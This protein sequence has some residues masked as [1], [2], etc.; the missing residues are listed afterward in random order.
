MTAKSLFSKDATVEY[1]VHPTLDGGSLWHWILFNALDKVLGGGTARSRGRAGALARQKARQL[2]RRIRNVR[3]T[4]LMAEGID[5]K[6]FI[7]QMGNWIDIVHKCGYKSTPDTFWTTAAQGSPIYVRTIEGIVGDYT[8][9]VFSGT[10]T[11]KGG[12]MLIWVVLD[13]N[14]NGN[15][16]R[17][18]LHTFITTEKKLPFVLSALEEIVLDSGESWAEVDAAVNKFRAQES[19]IIEAQEHTGPAA[20]LPVNQ[21]KDFIMGLEPWQARLNSWTDG[22]GMRPDKMTDPKMKRSGRYDIDFSFRNCHLSLRV[23]VYFKPGEDQ[24]PCRV[25]FE[26]YGPFGTPYCDKSDYL[27]LDG[28][29]AMNEFVDRLEPVVLTLQKWPKDKQPVQ[30]DLTRLFADFFLWMINHPRMKDYI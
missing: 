20:R 10:G 23:V 14:D 16:N 7:S 19:G 30:E 17:L 12:G 21:A 26:V 11:A 13:Y 27:V 5:V 29:N 18:V 28:D 4:G 24:V 2:H 6:K 1:R 25:F 3:V 15:Q 9:S 8:I 22:W